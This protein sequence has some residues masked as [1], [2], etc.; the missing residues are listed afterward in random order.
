VLV[1]AVIAHSPPSIPLTGARTLP[2]APASA[3]TT[4]TVAPALP[5]S[6]TP[7][8]APSTAPATV[9]PAT[10]ARAAPVVTT[11]RPP[12]VHGT[13]TA[14]RTHGP[15]LSTSPP[16]TTKASPAVAPALPHVM[17][18]MME[19]ESQGNLIGNPAAPNVNALAA[20]YGVATASYAVGHP[21]LPNYLE[22]LAGSN[23]G[24]S[25]DGTP[26]SE[27]VPA[28]APTLVNQLETAGVPWRA[29]LESMP[30]AGYTGGD[31]TCCG[32][33]YYQ[34]HNPFV[35]FPSVTSLPDFASDVVPSTNMVSDLD[36][37]TPPAFV[38]VTPNGADDMHD[39][40][41]NDGE[42]SPS[43]GDA[44]LGSFV[45]QVQS[46]S[47]YAH[48]GRIVIEWDEGADSDTSGTG[49]AGLG[50][51][52]HIVTIV[53]SAALKASPQQDANPVNTAGILHSLENAYGLPLLGDAAQASNGDIDSL[54]AGL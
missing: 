6:T 32:G 47:W 18:V 33:Q 27:G 30:S 39:G 46:T 35:Y 9:A 50:G 31:S 20:A 26:S 38:W 11:V 44:W 12:S 28:G 53:V 48:N 34:H 36:A 21:S 16:S 24:V 40:V 52:G 43:V 23:Y 3:A 5:T 2:D 13:G 4:T 49:P 14:R 51:G 10:T 7:A 42:V 41:A 1:A 25:D 8:V 17:V 54:L 19:N 22:M 37:A 45:A 29:Y 15:K